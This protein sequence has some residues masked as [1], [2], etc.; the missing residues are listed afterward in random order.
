MK[1]LLPSLLLIILSS[2]HAE[3]Q[4]QVTAPGSFTIESKILGEKCKA[5]VYLPYDYLTSKDRYPVV[6]VLDAEYNAAFTAEAA[7]VLAGNEKIPPSIIIG[8]T[9]NNRGRDFTPAGDKGWTPPQEMPSSGGA[10]QFLNY[11]EKE[12]I[13]FV[14]TN[15]RTESFK[16]IIGHSLGGLLAMHS[17]AIRPDLFQ[18][19]IALE[20]SLWWNDGA[21]GKE[22]MNF[23]DTHPGYKGKLFI[24]RIKMPREVWF[25]IN[26]IIVDYFEK[27]RPAGLEYNYMEL[28]KEEHATMVFPATYFGMRDIFA[29]Y[30]FMTDEKP[31]EKTITA[32]YTNLSA[33]Y[34]YL[35][36]MPQQQFA[37]L[38]NVALHEKRFPDAIKYGEQRI[39]NYPTSYRAYMDLG[40]TYIETGNKELAVKMLT[41]ALE[42]H[43]G[44]ESILQLLKQAEGK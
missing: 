22:T 20:S 16:V 13:P 40:S 10:D 11:I 39:Q 25:P 21:V 26:I 17:F 6:Y 3:A 7:T 5:F 41:K 18:A 38:W 43:P 12:L 1:Q 32:Y 30:F 31:N 15:Y 44:D 27:K 37:I 42:L 35:V 36:K 4:S 24:A 34:G 28:D 33:K 19:T 23:L 29:D 8:I 9:T 2:L 14:N